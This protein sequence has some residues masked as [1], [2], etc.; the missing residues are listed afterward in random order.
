MQYYAFDLL[1]LNGH[2]TCDLPLLER[3]ELLEKI[4]PKNEVIKYSDHIV[5]KGISFFEA[6]KNKNLEGIIAKKCDSQYSKA[7]SYK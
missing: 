6:A 5:E 7:K 2:D 1:F 3:K 4:I